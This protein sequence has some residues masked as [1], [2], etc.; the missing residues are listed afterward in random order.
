[1]NQMLK[2]VPPPEVYEYPDGSNCWWV[3]FNGSTFGPYV[4][5]QRAQDELEALREN[6]WEPDE[7]KID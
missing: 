4:S 7:A 6:P 2:I 5:W 1:M 3:A